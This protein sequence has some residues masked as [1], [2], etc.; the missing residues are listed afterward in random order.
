MKITKSLLRTIIKE[1]ILKEYGM[2]QDFKKGMRV[3]FNKLEKVVKTK[4]MP[5]GREKTTVDYVRVPM[6]GV[7]V[8]KPMI[9]RTSAQPGYAVVKV[10]GEPDT[11]TIR[12]AELRPA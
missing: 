1:E 3:T 8:E 7:I 4:T 11:V 6:E 9:D 12:I 5:S 10:D 2:E